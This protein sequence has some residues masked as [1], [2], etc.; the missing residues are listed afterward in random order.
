MLGALYKVWPW[1]NKLYKQ[2]SSLD[3][4]S[5]PVFPQNYDGDSPAIVKAIAFFLIGFTLLFA[6]E[7]S[8]KI[9]EK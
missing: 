6:I 3:E 8:K 5:F 7:K 2:N 1:Q 9:F 4:I